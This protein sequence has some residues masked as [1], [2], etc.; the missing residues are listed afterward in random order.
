MGGCQRCVC[1]CGALRLWVV[2]GGFVGSVLGQLGGGL[3]VAVFRFAGLV[4]LRAGGDLVV[5]ALF[6]IVVVWFSFVCDCL[7]W[8]GD[9]VVGWF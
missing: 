7:G 3:W 9:L 5:L 6:A 2:L 4:C 8:F 1:W